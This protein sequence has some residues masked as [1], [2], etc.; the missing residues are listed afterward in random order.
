MGPP[1]P[2]DPPPS[3]LTP[4]PFS[5]PS[6]GL[7]PLHVAVSTSNHATVLS[8]LEHGADIDAV[9]IKSG[10]SPLLHTVENNNLA[11]VELLLQRGASVNAQSYGGNTALHAASGRG[12]LEAVRLL[13]RSGADGALKN[14]HNDTPL[15]VAK[16]K[17][18]IDILRGKAS[19]VPPPPDSIRE[20]SSPATSTASSPGIQPTPNGLCC[21]SPPATPSPVRTPNPHR[22]ALSPVSANQ[23]PE[24]PEPANRVSTPGPL[25]GVKL[26]RNQASP[27][28]LQPM[29]FTGTPK[30]FLPLAEGLLDPSFCGAI[31]PFAASGQEPGASRLSLL[32][33]GYH[34]PVVSL[35]PGLLANHIHTRDTGMDQSW[36][37]PSG[38]E[39]QQLHSKDSGAGGS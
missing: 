36:N 12:L 16:N 23:R 35:T 37:P 5:P 19:R 30:L 14:Y 27:T 20:G 3:L 17:R 2:D 31:Y 10:R 7:T 4:P 22:A 39:G 21:A 29:G 24:D 25:C 1:H 9:D 38:L 8:L 26:E 34:R 13:V 11:M 32:P 18:V 6:P 15:M 33:V 28:L